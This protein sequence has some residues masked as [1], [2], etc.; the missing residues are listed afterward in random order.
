MYF[1]NDKVSWV[2]AS[3]KKAKMTVKMNGMDGR[4]TTCPYNVNYNL[5]PIKPKSGPSISFLKSFNY[6]FETIYGERQ[7]LSHRL[8]QLGMLK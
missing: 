6:F 8:I 2:P 7:R 3:R 1:I 5:F 4:L